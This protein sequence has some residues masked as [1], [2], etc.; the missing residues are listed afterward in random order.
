MGTET[1]S[2][3]P[4][5]FK[6]GQHSSWAQGSR[7]RPEAHMVAFLGDTLHLIH[8]CPF[9]VGDEEAVTSVLLFKS[10]VVVVASD[11]FG[12]EI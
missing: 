9:C 8:C 6:V 12:R 1:K 5:P 2:C 3:L 7:H 10:S 4:D 11:L